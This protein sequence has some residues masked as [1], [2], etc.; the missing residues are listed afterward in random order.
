MCDEWHYDFS[1]FR[2]WS[3]SNGYKEGLT[4]DR[5]N[6]DD[7]YEPNNCRWTTQQEQ[8][9]NTRRNRKITFNG[10]TQTVFEWIKELGIHRNTLTKRYESG[11]KPLD[12]P[13]QHTI[14]LDNKT[15]TLVEWAKATGISYQTIN[16][17]RKKGLSAKEILNNNCGDTTS[18]WGKKIT[19]DGKTHTISEWADITGLSCSTIQNRFRR[20]WSEEKIFSPKKNYIN[21]E[22]K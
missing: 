15:M 5:K 3:L 12:A 19:V 9:L 10:T 14:T 8:T 4:I 20:G 17:R 1:L 6:N 2:E 16:D 22:R 13:T 11:S 18:S 7:D 21:Y